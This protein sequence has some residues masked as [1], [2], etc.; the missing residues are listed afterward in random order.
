M[1]IARIF[2]GIDEKLHKLDLVSLVG[3]LLTNQLARLCI[4]QP[5]RCSA[6]GA[7]G[8]VL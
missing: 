6:D 4:F 2:A 5:V 3:F 8:G 7:V 1:C